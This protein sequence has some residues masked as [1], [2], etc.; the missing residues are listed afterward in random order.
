MAPFL[1]LY[2]N[3]VDVFLGNSFC[4][5]LRQPFK[6]VVGMNCCVCH[7]LTL[8]ISRISLNLTSIN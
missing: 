4:F 1:M 5:G 3:N 6:A 8:M 2:S 7:L